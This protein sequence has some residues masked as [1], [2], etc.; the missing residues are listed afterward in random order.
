MKNNNN[1]SCNKSYGKKVDVGYH[2][3]KWRK[4]INDGS[5]LSVLLAGVGGQGILLISKVLSEAAMLDGLDVKVSEV[6]GMAQRGGSVVGG[7]RIGKRVY[8]P[9]AGKADFI[10]SLEKLEALRYINKLKK[11]GFII[12]SDAEIYPISVYSG[13]ISYPEDIISDIESITF[14]YI[15]VKALEIAKRLNEVRAANIILLGCLS[16][17]IPISYKCWIES[18]K[19]NIPH[20]VIDVN[21]K[22]FEEGKRIIN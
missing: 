15:V 17:F 19:K 22:A 7:V 10:M 11:D 12:L 14:N 16:N 3:K 13:D 4:L 2:Q 8:S 18:I 1:I 9:V 20:N 6:H 5:V 21:L